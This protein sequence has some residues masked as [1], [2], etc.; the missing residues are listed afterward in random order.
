MCL[1][2]L[3][4]DLSGSDKASTVGRDE[5]VFAKGGEKGTPRKAQT[6]TG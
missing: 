1:T 3:Q 4:V 5:H 2:L 6:G